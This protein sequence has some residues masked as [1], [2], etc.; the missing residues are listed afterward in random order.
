MII[1]HAGVIWGGNDE[2]FF[3]AGCVVVLREEAAARIKNGLV[4]DVRG[5]SKRVW[6]GMYC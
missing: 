2:L 4:I 1:L 3:W 6:M 5:T